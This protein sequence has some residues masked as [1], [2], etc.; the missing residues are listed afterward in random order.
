MKPLAVHHVSINVGDVE[1]GV[2]FY[3]TV[4]G[5]SVRTDRPELGIA[6]AWLDLGGQQVHLIEG[7]VPPNRGQHFAVQVGDLDAAVDELRARGISVNDPV[8]VGTGRQTFIDDPA[9]N[10]V[11]LHQV[12]SSSG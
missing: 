7:E 1:Q 5:A 4:L 6:G 2:A 8:S 3:T 9:G 12:A 10:V 11:E